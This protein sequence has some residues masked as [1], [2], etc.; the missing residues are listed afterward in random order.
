MLNNNMER[1]SVNMKKLLVI[2][3]E[4][5]PLGGGGGVA[6]KKMYEGFAKKGYVVDYVTTLY[7]DALAEEKIEGVNIYRVKIWGKRRLKSASMLSLLSFPL[8]AY[9]KACCLCKKNQYEVVH[10]HFAVPSGPLGA[11]IAKRFSLKNVLF[12]YGGDI[13]D[14]TKR[15]SPHKW[16]ILRKCI[17]GLLNK[18]D[19]VITESSDIRSKAEFYYRFKKN[20]HVIPLI[21]NKIA[22]NV[23][24]R[25]QL[26]M[27]EEKIYL[28][29]VGRLV[30]RKGFSFLIDIVAKLDD[31]YVL[32]IIGDGPE[33]E[34]LYA[35]INELGIRERV[36]LLGIVEEERKFQYLFNSDIYVLSSI[37]EGFGI[38]LQEA[39]QVG[40]PIV[41]TDNGGQ[42]DII[43]DGV[44]G[45]LIKYGDIF[46]A[47]KAIGKLADDKSLSMRIANNNKC[48][49]N[50]FSEEVIVNQCI[51]IMGE[52]DK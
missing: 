42:V 18:A 3:Y 17:S 43:S 1:I 12:I 46:Q 29:S 48:K 20:I 34:N 49:I 6:A 45:F 44:N 41:A 24:D 35:K 16:W 31:R 51:K 19:A 2:N 13:Y 5:P 28:I 14:P 50:S 10:T 4:Y 15:F 39:M 52:R 36:R 22:F 9:K 40:L 21:Y 25:S 11:I 33:K 32:N 38:V 27:V 47:A 23:V 8:C 37:H 26:G 30:K 7:E